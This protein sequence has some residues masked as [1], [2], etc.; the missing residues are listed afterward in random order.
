M[1]QPMRDGETWTGLDRARAILRQW[2]AEHPER[3]APWEWLEEALLAHRLWRRGARRARALR[4]AARDRF[5]E[6]ARRLPPDL[7]QHAMGR[8]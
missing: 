8:R 7:L 2:N 4:A 5:H 6:F 1:R 3:P